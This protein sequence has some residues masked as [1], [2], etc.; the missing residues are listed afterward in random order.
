M[1]GALRGQAAAQAHVDLRMHVYWECSSIGNA[2]MLDWVVQM[3][4]RRA[5]RMGRLISWM[6]LN[7]PQLPLNTSSIDIAL[8]LSRGHQ[9][10]TSFP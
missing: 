9:P 8:V 3:T 2:A 10:V 6:L 7:K 4:V 1:V 5:R